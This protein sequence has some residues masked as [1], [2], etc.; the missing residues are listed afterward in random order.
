MDQFMMNS[1]A[2]RFDPFNVSAL[3]TLPRLECRVLVH[4][5]DVSSI[6]RI[7]NLLRLKRHLAIV[8]LVYR[9]VR[10]VQLRT[11]SVI[12]PRGGVVVMDTAT[13]LGCNS[14]VLDGICQFMQKQKV[15]RNTA[16]LLMLPADIF[17]RL[18]TVRDAFGDDAEDVVRL[19]EIAQ[20]VENYQSL[21]IVQLLPTDLSNAG[22]PRSTLDYWSTCI[23]L[24]SRLMYHHR[25]FLYVTDLSRTH[26]DARLFLD[27][28]IDVLSIAEFSRGFLAKTVEHRPFNDPAVSVWLTPPVYTD[29]QPSTAVDSVCK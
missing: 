22:R 2:R 12:F 27:N 6:W 20:I 9:T 14:E 21:G 7:P 5:S 18:D 4:A 13:L 29:A 25:H 1:G 15:E 26:G 19:I 10:D 23:M 3:A 17:T 8:F 28:G 16:W 11:A 24:Q